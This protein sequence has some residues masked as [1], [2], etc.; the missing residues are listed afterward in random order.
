MIAIRAAKV[1]TVAANAAN[2]DDHL[3]GAGEKRWW[4]GYADHG[5]G[6][7]IDDQLQPAPHRNLGIGLHH[8]PGASGFPGRAPGAG[9]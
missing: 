9:G 1:A 5:S 2:S 6:L 8:I 4:D 7:Q 3:I